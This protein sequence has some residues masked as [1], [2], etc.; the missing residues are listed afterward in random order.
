MISVNQARQLLS[1]HSTRGKIS[2]VN[3]QE[4][5]GR[6]LAE[7]IFSPIAVPSFDNSAMDGYAVAFEEGQKDWNMGV[8]IQ[9]GDTSEITIA[10]GQAARIFT[11]AKIPKGADT[12]IPQELVLRNEESNRITI[13]SDNINSGSHVRY[14][15]SQCKK[16]ELILKE[17]TR[18]SPG[19]IGLLASVGIAR[20]KIYKAPE[21]AYI[22]TGNELKEVGSPL[23]MG[24]IYNSNGPMLEALLQQAGITKTSIYKAT[25]NK[26]ELQ[27][28]INAALDYHEVLI[29]SGGISVGDFD[30]VKECL[31]TAGVK[32]LFYKIS[33][34]PGKPMFVGKKDGIWVFA[35][36]GNPASVLSCFNQYVKPCLKYIMGNDEVWQPDIILPIKEDLHKAPGL[37]FFLK[38]KREGNDLEILGGQQSFNLQAFGTANCL[39]ELEEGSEVISAG[40]SVKIYDL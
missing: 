29:L 38:A 16:G 25:D 15:G 31:E 13:N 23:Q 5:H 28:I 10:K 35:L 3:L 20:V 33:Q 34:R 12:V 14:L 9:A 21:V 8:V 32:E 19:V 40:T 6:I 24:E 30:F 39:V 37:T 26:A 22:I 4:S 1:K 17:G 7:N 18:I 27:Q 2:T 36:P 11:G